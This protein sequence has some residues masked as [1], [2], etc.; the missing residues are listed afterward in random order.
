MVTINTAENCRVDHEVGSVSPG[1][2]AD[3]LILIVNDLEKFDI[4]PQ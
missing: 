4:Y 2:F 1:R 3:T